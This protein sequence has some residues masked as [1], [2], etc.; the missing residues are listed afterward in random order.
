MKV[1]TLIIA[2]AAMLILAAPAYA[3]QQQDESAGDS[4]VL[5]D[6]VL[7]VESE[8]LVREAEELSERESSRAE[9]RQTRFF[10][11]QVKA[12]SPSNRVIR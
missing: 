5:E 4:A 2:I 1:S 11:P 3:S 12:A 7:L 10:R 9:T 6:R 8:E